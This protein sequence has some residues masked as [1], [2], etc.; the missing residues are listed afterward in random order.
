MTDTTPP[1]AILGLSCAHLFAR[2]LHV[3]AE[4][5]VADALDTAPRTADEL[6]RAV[7]VSPDGLDRLLRLLETCNLFTCDETGRWSHTDTS[8]WLRADHPKSLRAFARMIGLPMSWGAVTALEHTIR[9]GEPGICTLH[10]GGLFG[11][12]DAH[13]DEQA[14][15]QQAMTAKAHG[16]VAAVLAA[17]DFSRHHRIADVGGG[18][19]HL[20][21]AVLAAHPDLTGVLFELPPVAAEVEP[22][23]RLGVVAGDFF[24]DPLPHSD[25]YV[26]MDIIHDWDDAQ[27]AAILRAVA[28]A[29]HGSPATVL[30]VETILPAGPEPHWAKTLDVLMLALTG[31]RQRT[32]T[33][34]EALLDT[35]GID[36]IRAIPTATPFSIVEG[37]VR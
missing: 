5:G 27:A 4:L 24:T 35:A 11:Y 6:A 2:A 12:L 36:L 28:R 20:L 8:R 34:Y 23:P 32:L 18:R 9:T 33:G 15:F 29:A 3:V 10:P 14:V 30:I 19:G 22:A 31:G 37:R 1:E 21:A 25:A 26:L 16:D 17:Y 7:E 13:L